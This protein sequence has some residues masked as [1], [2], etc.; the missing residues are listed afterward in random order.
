MKRI[1]ASLTEAAEAMA[2]IHD[3]TESSAGKLGAAGAKYYQQRFKVFEN[4]EN[5][6]K[7]PVHA[8]KRTP[9]MELQSFIKTNKGA[10][11]T[12][13]RSKRKI[14]N[15]NRLV[16]N[17]AKKK[18][19]IVLPTPAS[20]GEYLPS[21]AGKILAEASNCAQALRK[22]KE[23]NY[24]DLGK[25]RLYHLKALHSSGMPIQD[26]PPSGYHTSVKCSDGQARG[27]R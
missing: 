9:L 2:I 5:Q 17:N 12:E 19:E 20:G 25:S 10:P 18:P 11:N 27:G 6:L 4:R 3:E 24:T 15:L 23:L 13:T 1:G 14:S 16:L 22:M 7:T 26:H 21:E 8:A